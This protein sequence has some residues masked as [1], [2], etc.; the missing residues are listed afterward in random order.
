VIIEGVVLGVVG[1][2]GALAITYAAWAVTHESVSELLASVLEVSADRQ[3]ADF[4]PLRDALQVAGAGV[5]AGLL[6]GAFASRRG[7]GA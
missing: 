6:G 7:R 4:L 2:M 5:V 1:A 3:V